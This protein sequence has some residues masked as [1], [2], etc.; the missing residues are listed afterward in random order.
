MADPEQKRRVE[1]THETQHLSYGHFGTATY[2]HEYA[3]SWRFLRRD[4]GIGEQA[5]LQNEALPSEPAS[6][7]RLLHQQVVGP[8]DRSRTHNQFLLEPRQSQRPDRLYRQYPDLAFTA[9]ILLDGNDRTVRRLAQP[10]PA[11]R[12]QRLCYGRASGVDIHGQRLES[13]GV[14]IVA[15]A[16]GPAQAHVRISPIETDSLPA[17]DRSVIQTLI[18]VHNTSKN[19]LQ[20]R[21]ASAETILQICFSAHHA[22]VGIRKASSITLLR[23]LWRG[24]A[25]RR[26]LSHVHSSSVGLDNVLVLPISRTGGHPLAHFAFDHREER[27]LAVVDVHGV[28]SVWSVGGK[29]S[30]SARVLF[31]AHLKAPGRLLPYNLHMAKSTSSEDGWHRICWLGSLNAPENVLLACSRQSAA[32]Y[33]VSGELLGA[34][35]M[36]IGT[37]SAKYWILDVQ[38]CVAYHDICFVLTSTRIMAMRLADGVFD[39]ATNREPLTL[40]CSRD[41]FR[42][43]QDL[44]LR[45][46]V[47][48]L[49]DEAQDSPC[50]GRLP[51]TTTLVHFFSFSQRNKEITMHTLTITSEALGSPRTVSFSDPSSF[52]LPDM[53]LKHH[54]PISDIIFRVASGDEHTL[55]EKTTGYEAS[56]MLLARMEDGTIFEAVYKYTAPDSVGYHDREMGPCVLTKST[57]RNRNVASSKYADSDDDMNEFIVQ[58]SF[59]GAAERNSRRNTSS[60]GRESATAVQS[61]S[62][63]WVDVLEGTAVERA[64][65]D[66]A[67]LLDRLRSQPSSDSENTGRTLLEKMPE[68]GVDDIEQASEAIVSW[69]DKSQSDTSVGRVGCIPDSTGTS[70]SVSLLEQYVN[71]AKKHVGSLPANIPDRVRVNTERLARTAASETFLASL[72]LH[73]KTAAEVK[74]PEDLE[75]AGESTQ[76]RKVVAETLF[77]GETTEHGNEEIAPLSH[78]RKYTTINKKALF[79]FS[80]QLVT[81]VVGHLPMDMD[82]DP[83][84][85][86]YKDAELALAMARNRLETDL[87]PQAKRHAEKVARYEKKR[88][89][90]ERRKAEDIAFQ[91]AMMP[92]QVMSSQL[93]QA[94]SSQVGNGQVMNATQPERGAFGGRQKMPKAGKKRVAGF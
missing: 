21:L 49:T 11:L 80:R 79:A 47:L 3:H 46:S 30:S 6:E 60:G 62:R 52:P 18:S 71:L 16:D 53:I 37:K 24:R 89:E 19:V 68:A 85:Y 1:H 72:T 59:E 44:T 56:V 48:E 55:G 2:D 8:F 34:V 84:D 50:T 75:S 31:Q 63:A 13:A 91:H 94:G 73:Q 83:A 45:M 14:P 25:Q 12:G 54:S 36:R 77:S 38:P 92:N 20:H 23:P 33:S 81:E 42:G 61:Q 82:T 4:G 93:P 87:D 22:I 39:T 27:Q 5:Q 65:A 7:F 40:M 86:S 69:M 78:L 26:H 88:L 64:S 67:D 51:V 29:G 9:P 58:D 15:S 10:D 57:Q 32:V 66:L 43:Q 28:W 90:R 74:K 17:D 70:S 76:D 41:H 35:D